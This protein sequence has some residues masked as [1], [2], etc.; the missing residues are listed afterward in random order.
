[1]GVRMRYRGEL[2]GGGEEEAGTGLDGY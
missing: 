1:M 2:V